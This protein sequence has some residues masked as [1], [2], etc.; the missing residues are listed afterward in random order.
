MIE[1]SQHLQIPI[2]IFFSAHIVI[3]PYR[4]L[5]IPDS[6]LNIFKH[7]TAVTCS[8][9]K[10]RLFKCACKCG[11]QRKPQLII[12]I[13]PLKSKFTQIIEIIGF[14]R[15]Y[16]IG[17]ECE[18]FLKDRSIYCESNLTMSDELSQTINTSTLYF[19]RSGEVNKGCRNGA[20]AMRLAE[21][22]LVPPS[23]GPPGSP[24]SRRSPTAPVDRSGGCCRT[25]SCRTTRC[26]RPQCP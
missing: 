1:K 25:T 3:N 11:I 17:S 18:Y 9:K 14:R 7:N 12:L 16:L 13:S 6:I 8:F 19:L 22:L 4:C 20:S 5:Q 23:V 15:H 2:E 10:D 21:A 24:G 26:R